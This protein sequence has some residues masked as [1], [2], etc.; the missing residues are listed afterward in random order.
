MSPGMVPSSFSGVGIKGMALLFAIMLT[1]DLGEATRDSG[2]GDMNADALAMRA[3]KEEATFMVLRLPVLVSRT[4][5]RGAKG[6]KQQE[7]R[8]ARG[9]GASRQN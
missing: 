4:V 5:V 8:R 3:M 6:R 9:A 2:V 1:E 7:E